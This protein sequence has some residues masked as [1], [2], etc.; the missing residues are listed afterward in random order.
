MMALPVRCRT[1]GAADTESTRH[2]HDA[3]TDD[4]AVCG[5]APSPCSCLASGDREPPLIALIVLLL[6]EP[7]ATL[8]HPSMFYDRVQ[9]PFVFL[10]LQTGHH[11][12]TAAEV[13]TG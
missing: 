1:D 5:V 3:N 13:H 12:G 4:G 9:V 8:F 6:F 2:H 11:D 7:P 10:E